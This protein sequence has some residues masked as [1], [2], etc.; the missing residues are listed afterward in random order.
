MSHFCLSISIVTY[1]PDPQQFAEALHSLDK[2]IVAL[3]ARQPCPVMLTLIDNGNQTAAMQDCLAFVPAANGNVIATGTNVGYGRGHNFAITTADSTYHLIMNP[4][5]ILDEMA[6]V[7]GIDCLAHDQ[8]VVAV[9]PAATDGAGNTL[10]LCKTFPSVIDLALRGFA[11][12]FL[13][14]LFTTRLAAYE[15]RALVDKA[16]SAPVDLIS[17]CFMLCRTA[18]LHKAGGF[19]STFF[20][21]FEDFALSL[22]L[23]KYGALLYL[24]ACK[25]V[26]FGGDAGKKGFKHIGYFVASAFQFFRLYGWKFV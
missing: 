16:L 19:N 23:K 14:A 13:K 24:P 25:I 10:Y 26:H 8:Q 1:K 15:N 3:Q 5:V 18:A 21:Y 9:S 20:L 17:G 22:E 11:P 12:G 2:A 4:D 6:L 7:A